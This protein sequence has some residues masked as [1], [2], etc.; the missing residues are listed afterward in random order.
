MMTHFTDRYVC[1]RRHQLV[2]FDW[3]VQERCNSSAFAMDLCLSRYKIME[4]PFRK[5]SLAYGATSVQ[6][7]SHTNIRILI[8]KIRQFHNHLIIIMGILYLK[9]L[10]SY[11]NRVLVL[12]NQNE[13]IAIAAIFLQMM[14]LL[15]K[16]M[17]FHNSVHT[18]TWKLKLIH[19]T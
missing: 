8:V 1:I 3:L 9:R 12:K 5:M 7:C 17:A 4:V 14:N 2:Y 15:P 10:S 13:I 16:L 6:R 18:V 19:L 11:W